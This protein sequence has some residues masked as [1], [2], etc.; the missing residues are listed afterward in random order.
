MIVNFGYC[1]TVYFNKD[2]S[3]DRNLSIILSYK[4]QNSV[5]IYAYLQLVVTNGTRSW[6]Q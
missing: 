3:E 5:V 1:G 4:G 6:Q 2:A